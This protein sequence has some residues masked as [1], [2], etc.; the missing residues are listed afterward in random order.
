MD[1]LPMV[2]KTLFGC[3]HTVYSFIHLIFVTIFP[4]EKS[5]KDKVILVS[6]KKKC[7]QFE[8]KN[9]HIHKLEKKYDLQLNY[10]KQSQTI[11]L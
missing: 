2:T 7:K 1:Y 8:S 4:V 11:H 3:L 10:F 9:D 5:L 6:T